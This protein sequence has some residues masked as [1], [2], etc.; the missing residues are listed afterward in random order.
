MVH[1]VENK[2]H[3]SDIQSPRKLRVLGPRLAIDMIEKMDWQYEVCAGPAG[4]AIFYENIIG[5][6]RKDLQ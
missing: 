3:G 2:Q 5:Y 4:L 1:V 6:N